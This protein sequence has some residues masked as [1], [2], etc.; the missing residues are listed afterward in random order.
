MKLSD[1][2]ALK[3]AYDYMVFGNVTDHHLFRKMFERMENS[4]LVEME[5]APDLGKLFKANEELSN[6]S[7]EELF[8]ICCSDEDNDVEVTPD[9]GEVLHFLFKEVRV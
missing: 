7:E 6:L 2:P 4:N 8:E 3:K 5:G 9:T 1:Y